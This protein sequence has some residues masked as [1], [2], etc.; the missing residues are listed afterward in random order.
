MGTKQTFSTTEFD[1]STAFEI[2]FER[3]SAWFAAITKAIEEGTKANKLF[4]DVRLGEDEGDNVTLN[5]RGTAKLF[6]KGLLE[7][8]GEEIDS[9]PL[10]ADVTGS[11]ETVASQEVDPDNVAFFGGNGDVYESGDPILVT[12]GGGK[13]NLTGSNADDIIAG[14]TGDD[15]IIAGRGN[16]FVKG[17][18]GND[19]ISGQQG[20]DFL[21]GDYSDSVF[22]NERDGGKLWNDTIFGGDGDDWIFGNQGNDS[23]HGGSDDDTIRG[24]LGDDTIDGGN[25]NDQLFGDDGDDRVSG[26]R[27]DDELFGDAG[28]DT[29]DGQEGNDTVNGGEGDDVVSGGRKGNPSDGDNFV[30]GGTGNDTVQ[31]GFGSDT[32]IGGEGDDLLRGGTGNDTMTGGVEGSSNSNPGN[33]QDRNT[34]VLEGGND[35][36]TDFD[37]NAGSETTFDTLEFDFGGSKFSLSTVQDFVDFVGLIETDGDVT[38]DAG[39]I[40]DDLVLVFA[41]NGSQTDAD[42]TD[43]VRLEDFFAVDDVDGIDFF[44]DGSFGASK[45]FDD[46]SSDTF[47]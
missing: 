16:D 29:V 25:Q 26:G 8:D 24:G 1:G 32:L 6:N 21:N 10:N 15:T 46:V 41:R 14:N 4:G 38:T 27:D 12:G 28:N 17:G 18:A 7:F 35:V 40:G 44:P 3:D 30:D 43:S 47:L 23:L 39:V 5:I 19:Y 45:T 13:D 20:N 37:A 42:I 34:F 36:I 11:F 9:D 31:A 2:W 22:H 33:T